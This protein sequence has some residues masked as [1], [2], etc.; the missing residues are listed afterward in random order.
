MQRR[1]G[2]TSL[3]PSSDLSVVCP[4]F[5]EEKSVFFTLDLALEKYSLKLR[6]CV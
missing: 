2:D 5:L 3:H 4:G 6:A 1:R